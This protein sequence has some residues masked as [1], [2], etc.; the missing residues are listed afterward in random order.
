MT[1]AA[2]PGVF[3]GSGVVRGMEKNN[4]F[5]QDHCIMENLTLIG[6]RL[7]SLTTWGFY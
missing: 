7:F 6:K 2:V 3:V 5:Q 4:V 1:L